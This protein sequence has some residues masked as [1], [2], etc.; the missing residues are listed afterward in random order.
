VVTPTGRHQ[1]HRRS[2]HHQTNPAAQHLQGCS[3]H[4][5][6]S[7]SLSLSSPARHST[8]RQEHPPP[9]TGGGE[10]ARPWPRRRRHRPPRRG[11]SGPRS[12]P[13]RRRPRPARR[14]S[15]RRGWRRPLRRRARVRTCPGPRGSRR[16]WRERCSPA[17]AAAVA[18]LPR[19]PP[20]GSTRRPR[21]RRGLRP[22]RSSSRS[23]PPGA[24]RCF[25]AS[26]CAL[27]LWRGPW[28]LVGSEWRNA[29]LSCR[30]SKSNQLHLECTQAVLRRVRSGVCPYTSFTR[31]LTCFAPII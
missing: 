13:R 18:G 3:R 23:S 2:D 10:H 20:L 31:K 15:G 5:S 16:C 17:A 22:R 26:A 14:R 30:G 12:I 28:R 11:W 9:L 21:S 24:V 27:C 19:R 8:R 6:S 29:A 1:H 4:H 25:V 7:L